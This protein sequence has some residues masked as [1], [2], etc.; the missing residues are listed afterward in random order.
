MA[1]Q[2]KNKMGEQRKDELQKVTDQRVINKMNRK[3][4]NKRNSNKN[5]RRTKEAVDSELKTVASRTNDLS[6]YTN[7]PN[8]AKDV[9]TLA[10]GVPV[11][12]PVYVQGQDS[13]ANDGIM[14]LLFT[15]SIGVSTDLT[16]PINRQATRFY[17]YLRSVQRAAASYDSADVMM[18]MLALDSAYTY[19]AFMRRIYG[20]AQL[21]TP[22]NK[23]YPRRLLLAM[24]VDPSI[25]NNLAD[26]RAYINRYALNIGRYAMPKSFDITQRHMWMCSGLYLDSNTTRAQ[27][28][29][30][31]PTRLFQ[32]DNTVTSGSQLAGVELVQASNVS[33]AANLFTLETLQEFGS[34]LIRNLENDED[35]MNISGDLFRAYGQSGLLLVEETK[36]NYA[37]APVYDQTVLSQIEN[38]TITGRISTATCKITQDP[39]VNNGAIIFQPSALLGNNLNIGDS[40]TPIYGR[41]YIAVSKNTP[42]NAHW[43]SPNPGQVMEMT[44]LMARCANNTSPFAGA[45][46]SYVPLTQTGTDIVNMVQIIVPGRN[47]S[48]AYSVITLYSN[49]IWL[50]SSGTPFSVNGASIIAHMM[51]FDWAPMLYLVIYTGNAANLE[52]VAADVDNFTVVS[53]DQMYNIHEAALL[54]VLD[55]PAPN[56]SR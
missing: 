36:D 18:Y 13:V 34:N 15:P 8:Y 11:G 30:F 4:Y 55:I 25:A 56:S 22:T 1:K 3:P 9:A 24:G 23:Y 42:I 6:W 53:E 2:E 38:C 44:R 31:V 33:S 54:S 19:W 26:F 17:T 43:D 41:N 16:S 47:D 48:S 29:M 32:W 49:T 45:S 21:F 46:E 52:S 51:Q 39:S 20:I 28:Y 10:F 5:Q 14:T 50:N 12:Q 27:T 7:F 37:V 35:T 40:T